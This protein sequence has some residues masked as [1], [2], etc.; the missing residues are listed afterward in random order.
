MNLNVCE[1]HKTQREA[2]G[3]ERTEREVQRSN[4]APQPRSN[5]RA[6][7]VI[8]MCPQ[9]GQ[10]F[11]LWNFLS[12]PAVVTLWFAFPLYVHHIHGI[13]LLTSIETIIFSLYPVQKL[14]NLFLISDSGPIGFP[15]CGRK[16]AHGVARVGT[17][18]DYDRQD[19]FQILSC[20]RDIVVT[21]VRFL[22]SA[23]YIKVS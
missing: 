12:L 16:G 9:S 7:R 5:L 17:T 21:L 6:K 2:R 23:L 11:F 15:I 10:I 1:E 14:P 18:S 22:V 8:R 20:G 3:P 19:Y 4:H 13:W